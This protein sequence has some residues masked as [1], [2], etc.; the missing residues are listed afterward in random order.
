MVQLWHWHRQ[1]HAVRRHSA[2][3][4]KQP[5]TSSKELKLDIQPVAES[6]D[7][8]VV[9]FDGKP[10]PKV[11]AVIYAPNDWEKQYKNDGAGQV[12]MLVPWKGQ[13]VIEVI[14]KEPVPSEFEGNKF[15]AVRH[16]AILTVV[17]PSG[18]QPEGTGGN[19]SGMGIAAESAA[20]DTK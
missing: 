13:Y 8:F 10:L 15:D 6:T 3:P 2:W 18:F 16:R 5:I 12:K 7:S 20:L 14:Y 11:K 19:T 4:L 1:A 17:Q 9:L